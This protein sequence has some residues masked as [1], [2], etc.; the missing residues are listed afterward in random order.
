MPTARIGRSVLVVGWHPAA[1]S[2]EARKCGQLVGGHLR[3]VATS[4]LDG[5]AWDPLWTRRLDVVTVKIPDGTSRLLGGLR[6]CREQPFTNVRRH[7]RRSG[8]LYTPRLVPGSPAIRNIAAGAPVPR[9]HSPACARS[10]PPLELSSHT[11]TRQLRMPSL[12]GAR[13][14]LR[15]PRGPP[16]N[17][18]ASEAS[19]V[20]GRRD[21]R[22][23][24]CRLGTGNCS[25]SP[26]LDQRFAH[27]THAEIAA[28]PDDFL[29]EYGRRRWM[30][31]IRAR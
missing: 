3:T 15:R 7:L 1:P 16:P 18:P 21:P 26:R 5:P 8:R 19:E 12:H 28:A 9:E 27:V 20:S 30:R 24:L 4:R 6:S 17:L 11:T 14:R 2:R 13:E 23:H 31:L 22:T 25:T 10:W 29:S